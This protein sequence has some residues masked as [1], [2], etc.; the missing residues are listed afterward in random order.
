MN[1]GVVHFDAFTF[2]KLLHQVC[3][4]EMVFACEQSFSV[5]YSMGWNG[6][7]AMGGIHGPAYH[8][9]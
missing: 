3:S 8:P 4:L 5:D 7:I 9:R 6:R 1:L 2:Q